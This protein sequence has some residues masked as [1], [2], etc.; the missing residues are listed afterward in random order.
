MIKIF[1]CQSG[2]YAVTFYDVQLKTWLVYWSGSKDL[3]K[4]MLAAVEC[5]DFIRKPDSAIIM[6]N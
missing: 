1:K 2:F 3:N 5:K 4:A 6:C